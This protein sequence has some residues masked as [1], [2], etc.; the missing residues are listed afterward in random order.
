M[1]NS[2]ST[3]KLTQLNCIELSKKPLKA[4]TLLELIVVMGIIVLSLGLTVIG[5]TRFRYS[6]E[7]QNGY[8]D[9]FSYIQNVENRSRNSV[10]S[11]A[12]YNSTGSYNES[13]PDYYVL[14]FQDDNFSLQ[15]CN[16]NGSRLICLSE[17]ENVKAERF[18]SVTIASTCEYVGVHKRDADI[19]RVD[20]QSFETSD[21]GICTVVVGHKS[22]SRTYTIILD[23]V[24]NSIDGE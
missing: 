18:S 5:I 9:I 21:T 23:L 22:I 15:A 2:T 10:S 8:S 17:E 3:D 20:S 24:S 1:Y 16:L 13:V 11:E 7:L 12:L 19:V 14:H 4:F 6:I